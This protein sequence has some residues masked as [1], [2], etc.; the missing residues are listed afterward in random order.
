MHIDPDK[1]IT[2]VASAFV[3]E[4]LN[5]LRINFGEDI[6][7]YMEYRV[8]RRSEVLRRELKKAIRE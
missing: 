3:T 1:E 2:P 4:E 7:E 5:L 8:S 6:V